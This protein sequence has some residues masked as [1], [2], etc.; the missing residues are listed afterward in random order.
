MRVYGDQAAISKLSYIAAEIDVD[1]LSED[2]KYNVTLTKPSGV[3]YMSEGTTTV[4]LKVASETTLEFEGISIETRNLGSAYGATTV[5]QE[6]TS[7][8]VIV[9]GVSNV[10]ENIKNTSIRAYVDLSGYGPGTHEVPVQVEG[11]NLT[12]TYTAKVKSIKIKIFNN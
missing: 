2:K 3:R 8:T 6:D 9:K 4:E 1:G 5:N 10:L 12:V 11:D 7:C